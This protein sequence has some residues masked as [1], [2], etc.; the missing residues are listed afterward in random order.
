VQITDFVLDNSVAMRWLLKSE[1][2][3]GQA[4]AE[5]VLQTLADELLILNSSSLWTS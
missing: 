1:K 5:A 2:A 3:S 4:Y